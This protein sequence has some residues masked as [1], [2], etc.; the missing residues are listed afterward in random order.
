MRKIS[1]A[2]TERQE[3]R[4]SEEEQPGSRPGRIAGATITSWH[5]SPEVDLSALFAKPS[6][7]ATVT[8]SAP[9]E[10]SRPESKPISLSDGTEITFTSPDHFKSVATV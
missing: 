3:R 4:G 9:A 10:A 1:K 8:G 5:G 2:R 6:R 7:R